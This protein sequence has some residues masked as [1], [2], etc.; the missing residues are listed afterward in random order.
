MLLK[1]VRCLGLYRQYLSVCTKD[2]LGK[3]KCIHNPHC[4]SQHLYLSCLL[5]IAMPSFGNGLPLLQSPLSSKMET[6]NGLSND[7]FP[8]ASQPSSLKLYQDEKRG[9]KKM[10]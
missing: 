8:L 9:K 2:T 4:F 6:K 3:G 7:F 10:F 1:S 5:A